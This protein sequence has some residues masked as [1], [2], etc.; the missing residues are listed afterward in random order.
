[1]GSI[2]RVLS[3]FKDIAESYGAKAL[4]A[5]LLVIATACVGSVSTLFAI[6]GE[7]TVAACSSMAFYGFCV[8][9]L[10]KW[11][12]VEKLPLCRLRRTIDIL[13]RDQRAVLFAAYSK[14]GAFDRG[15]GF[16][17]DRTGNDLLALESL[18]V[19][20]RVKDGAKPSWSLSQEAR[21]LLDNDARL[22]AGIEADYAPWMEDIR[23]RKHK[24]LIDAARRDLFELDR[25]GVMTL[26]DLLEA[27]GAV[28]VDEDG[29]NA[30]VNHIGRRL[31][32]ITRTCDGEFSIKAS[33]TAREAA[34][35]V[36]ADLRIE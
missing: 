25:F 16:F 3:K 17:D 18:G 20:V 23:D 7:A 1:M 15:C 10:L 14:R 33:A 8:G 5:S 6:D 21:R 22:L 28:K 11:L 30:M 13:P 24:H 34:P 12:L 29:M 2:K 32:D 27:D 31:L 4:L 35:L 9:W 26:V 36:F 19:V